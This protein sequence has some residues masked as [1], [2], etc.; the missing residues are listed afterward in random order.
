MEEINEIYSSCQKD[1]NNILKQFKN[2]I[3]RIRL[4]SQSLLSF[5]EKIKIKYY[6]FFIDLIKIA[7]ISI[8]DN[9]NLTIRPWDKSLISIIDKAIIDS[10]LG[11]MPTNKGEYIHIRIPIMTEEGR[12]HLIKK[13]KTETEQ[14]K[15]LIRVIR[16]KYNHMMKKKLNLSQDILK[17]GEYHIQ[18][19]TNNYIQKINEIF[20]LKEQEILTI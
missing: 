15:I 5:L 9:M 19:I 8:L 12:K 10:N 20:I 14:S 17:E 2:D 7:N 4:G 16:K 1:M 18:K 3:I 11:L 6:D 13:I